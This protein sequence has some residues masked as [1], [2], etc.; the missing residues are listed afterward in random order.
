MAAE[1]TGR[2]VYVITSSQGC[3]PNGAQGLMAGM[4]TVIRQ[5]QTLRCRI[6]SHQNGRRR[7]RVVRCEAHPGPSDLGR[8]GRRRCRGS[9]ARGFGS[10]PQSRRGGYTCGPWVRFE[11]W[12]L[13]HVFRVGLQ[14]VHHLRR[15]HLP[16]LNH[17]GGHGD[18][19]PCR[20]EW[21]R[22]WARMRWPYGWSAARR[23][24]ARRT[25]TV[26]YWRPAD[27]SRSNVP[28]HK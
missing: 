3:A 24:R 25:M 5:Q 13:N 16:I 8:C 20:R 28:I 21:V 7:G 4:E 10:R 14:V 15:N 19:L 27:P 6:A 26:S 2:A 1:L 23:M 18:N 12:L 9:T 11:G 17:C 22:T